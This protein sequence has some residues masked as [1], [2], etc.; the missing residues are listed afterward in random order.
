MEFVPKSIH[1]AVRN[2]NLEVL[3]MLLDAGGDIKYVDPISGISV[4][5]EAARAIK[6]K[7]SVI[8]ERIAIMDFIFQKFPKVVNMPDQNGKTPLH[9]AVEYPIVGQEET[10]EFLV[11]K[12]GADIT[13]KD[14]EGHTPLQKVIILRSGLNEPYLRM[15]GAKGSYY[16]VVH[17]YRMRHLYL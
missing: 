5:H 15:L 17:I 12:M 10:I 2:L 4:L 3:K 6:G 9:Y 1:L 7:K 11:K 8:L 16:D 14:K 13:L